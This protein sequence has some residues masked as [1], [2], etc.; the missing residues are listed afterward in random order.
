MATKKDATKE[1]AKPA[2]AKSKDKT[3]APAAKN[4]D[5]GGHK[6]LTQTEI[7]NHLADKSGLKRQQAKDFFNELAELAINEVKRSGEFTMPGFGKLV[8]SERKERD[9][10]NP[11]TGEKIKIPAKTTLKFRLG[12]TMKD[13]VG[14]DGK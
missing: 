2:A 3:A 7:V 12:K 5:N 4:T 6:R 11:A 1:T 14:N 9:G 8:L 10:R 13:T